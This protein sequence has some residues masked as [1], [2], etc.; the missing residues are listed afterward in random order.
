[1]ATR[2]QTQ[3]WKDKIAEY[4]EIYA[5]LYPGKRP[6]EKMIEMFCGLQDI[7]WPLPDAGDEFDFLD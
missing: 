3:A 7:P 1:M 4:E 6:P 5:G 2:G